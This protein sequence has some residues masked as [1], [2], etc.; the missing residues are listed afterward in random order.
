VSAVE[1]PHRIDEGPPGAPVLVLSNSLGATAAMW[2]PQVP[3][4]AEHFRIVRYEHRGH[5]DAPI[6]PEPYALDDIG[7]DV[8]ALLDRLDVARVHFCGLSLGGMVGMWLAVNAPERLERLVLCCTSP[9]LADDH[10]WAD[11]ARRV[12]EGGSAAVAETVVGR[13]FTAAYAAAHPD[14]VQRMRAMVAATPAAGY[15]GC[16]EAIRTMDLRP[17]L[18]RATTPTLVIAGAQ[19]PATPPAHALRIATLMPECRLTVIDAAHLANVEAPDEV[20]GLIRSHLL[21]SRTENRT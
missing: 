15:A 5:G 11:R 14:L 16:C 8:L 7:A 17:Q 21:N 10:D 2:D 20:T 4:L 13:W 6:P 1:L 18:A 3:A 9:M 12:R 19:D